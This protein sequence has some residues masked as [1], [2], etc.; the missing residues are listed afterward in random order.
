VTDELVLETG[1]V[2]KI[3]RE[4]AERGQQIIA[5]ID[6]PIRPWLYA[7]SGDAVK[8]FSSLV[9]LMDYDV[10]IG[11]YLTSIGRFGNWRGRPKLA[12]ADNLRYFYDTKPSVSSM[13]GGS[14]KT[15]VRNHYYKSACVSHVDHCWVICEDDLDVLPTN[16]RT[17]LPH[18]VPERQLTPTSTF[19]ADQSPLILFVGPLW[20]PPNFRG[21]QEFI[22]QAWSKILKFFPKA[23]LRAVG[24]GSPMLRKSLEAQNVEA[25]GYAQDLAAE[26]AR[27][28]VVIAPVYFGGGWQTKVTEAFAHAKPVV[29]VPFSCRGFKTFARGRYGL[30]IAPT[31][32]AMAD[33]V[34]ELLANR[35]EAAEMGHSIRRAALAEFPLARFEATILQTVKCH[36]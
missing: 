31:I 36:L 4:P 33:A 23:V 24:D 20:Y 22:R 29:A 16:H 15:K 34:I 26:Y 14:V 12:D 3:T 5:S 18:F 1:P 35:K 27:A 10:I 13:I 28:T 7:A 2:G 9:G 8:R 17:F 11:H 32:A 19:D 25:P 21:V 6:A 30:M